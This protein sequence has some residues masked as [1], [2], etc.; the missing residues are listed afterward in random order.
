MSRGET[1]TG[2]M[3]RREFLQ[4][5]TAVGAGLVLELYLP[6]KHEALAAE[7]S[8]KPVA[9]NAWVRIAP[10]GTATILIDKSEM[11][12]G[13]MTSLAMVLAEEMDLDWNEVRTEFA[14]AAPEYI[15]PLFG[16]QGTGGS[17]SVRGSW[18]PLAKAG[19]AAREML[20]AAA[21]KRWGVAASACSAENGGVVHHASKRRIGYGALAEE[22]AKL[23]VPEKPALKDP[24]SYRFIGKPLKRLDTFSKVTGR[25]GFGMD[26]RLPRMLHAAVERCPVFDGKVKSFDATRAKAVRGVTQ[27]VQISSGVAVIADNTWSALEGRRALEIVWD[28]GPKAAISSQAISKLYAE[29]AE[30]PGAVAR[31]DGD[32]EAGL[33][34]AA[35]KIEAVFEVPYLAHATMEPMNCAAD[36][37]RDGCDIYAPTQLQTGT[38][39]AGVAITGLKPEQVRVHTTFLGGG[40]GRRG[41]VDFVADAVELSKAAGAPVQVTWTREDDMRHDFY[42]PAAYTRLAAGLDAEGWPLAWKQRIVGPAV[43]LRFNPAAVRNGLD[44]L[45]VEGAA[46]IQYA[47]PNFYTDY[48]LTDAGVPVGFWR[49]VGNSFNGFFTE[50]FIDELARA[51][52]KDPFEFRRKLLA[53]AP[54]HLGVLELAA[55]KAGWGAALPAGR[56]RGIAVLESFGSCVAQVAEVDVHRSAR[57]VR[58]HR[59]VCAVNCGRFINPAI[60]ASQMESAI[61]FGLSAALKGAITIAGGR[62]E[63]SN[64]HDYEVLR[65]NE[66]P[67]IEVHIVP[68]NEAPGGVGEPGTPPIAPAVCNAIF[69]ATGKPIRRLPIRAEDLA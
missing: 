29:R 9:V 55:E 4:T 59:V 51:G 53:K 67:Q 43:M 1:K 44:P 39:R 3:P 28:E 18:A 66:M 24:R 17:T 11:G 50:C 35:K 21:A 60:I 32:A 16:V 64:F 7:L 14:P 48:V 40:F 58:V 10:D 36:V 49:S 52:G 57:E 46:D 15:N 19:A 5:T 34:G 38:Q 56:T 30:Q 6:G 65:L 68:S 61:V 2:K 42:R 26:V 8:G 37:R 23:P 22:A 20:I 31:N 47:I 69:A 63:Q 54:R 27:V 12:Q 13:V 41:E 62:V 45:A 25:A 33:A